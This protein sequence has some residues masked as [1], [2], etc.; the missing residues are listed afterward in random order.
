ML[1]I[2]YL[3]KGVVFLRY[4]YCVDMMFTEMDFYKRF[5]YAK[6]CGANAV[7]FWKWSNKDIGKVKE[8]LTKNELSC[9]IFNIDCRDEKLSYDLSRGILNAGRKDEFVMALKESIPIYKE[10]NAN[11]M[12]VLIGETL[13]SDYEEQ[14]VNIIRCL[15]A[16]VPI[17]EKENITIKLWTFVRVLTAKLRSKKSPRRD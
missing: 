6:K 5:V 16:A 17:V 4:S 10:L 14:I 2:A 1:N 11:G 15:E 8:E 13:E 3:W 9:S 7:E 12:I